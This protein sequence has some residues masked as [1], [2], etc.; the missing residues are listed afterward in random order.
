METSSGYHKMR[1]S[2]GSGE[3]TNIKE[4]NI[5]DDGNENKILDD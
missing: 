1:K 2:D 5:K 3:Q 4:W